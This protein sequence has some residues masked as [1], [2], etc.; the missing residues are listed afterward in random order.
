MKRLLALALLLAPAVHAQTKCEANINGFKIRTVYIMGDQ[1]NGVNWAYKHIGEE[2]CLTPVTDPSK[3]DAILEL[4]DRNA[5]LRQPAVSDS[6]VSVSCT[7]TN[8]SSVC[9]DSSGNMMTV[10]C[11]GGIADSRLS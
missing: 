5:E 8:S 3:A 11:S 9:T 4:Y 10:D 2:T 7:S 1:Y 6:S